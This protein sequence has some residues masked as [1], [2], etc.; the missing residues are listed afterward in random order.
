MATFFKKH[1][2]IYLEFSIVIEGIQ[3]FIDPVFD[4]VVNEVQFFMNWNASEAKWK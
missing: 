3:K 4:A 2:R 1:A